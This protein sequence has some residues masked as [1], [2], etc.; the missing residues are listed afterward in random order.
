[1]AKILFATTAE[2]V[3]FYP[4][5]ITD[6]VVHIDE[7][8]AQKKLSDI[9]D[10]IDYSG[11]ADKVEGATPNNFAGLDANGNLIDSGKKAADFKPVQTAV[12]DPTA[13]GTGVT[14]IDSISQDANGVI[15]ATK[16]TVQ[17][18]SETAAGLESA[19]HFNKVEEL[20]EGAQ[21]NVLETVKVNGTALTPDGNKAVDVLVA[22]GSANGTISVNNAD[23]AV[24]GLGSAAFTG[25]DAYDEAGA[26]AGVKAALEGDAEKDTKDSKTIEGAKKYADDLVNGVLT[27]LAGALQYKGAV[28]ANADLPTDLGADDKGAVYVVGTNGTYDGAAMEVGDYLIWNGAGWD[29]LNGENQ[30]SNEN[31]SLEIGTAKKV[32]TVDGT[33]ITVT[34]VEDMTKIEAVAVADTTDYADVTALFTAPGE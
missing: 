20:E 23:V 33:D 9:I 21:V 7:K 6:A 11:K 18:A 30:V 3:K 19:S 5:T 28:N 24:T 22:S 31:A 12:A 14:F 1:M 17:S 15:T 26:A 27:D 32:A 2:G 16:K 4:I 13:E 25:S 8:G 10:E 29:K 34:Q